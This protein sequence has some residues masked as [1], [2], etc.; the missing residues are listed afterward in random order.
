[1]ND[2]TIVIGAGIA[3][4]AAA[5]KLR[6]AG[7]DVLV[8]EASDRVGG[9]MISISH[10]GDSAEA[11]AQGIHTGYTET[12]KLIE[13]YGL[14]GDLVPQLNDQA[15][16]L[17]R[18]GQH[19]YP[20]GGVGM[21]KM[22]GWRGSFDLA[23]YLTKYMILAKKF[24]LYETHRDIPEYD[25]VSIADA[26]KW[27]GDDFRDFMLLPGAHAMVGSDLEHTNLYHFMNLMKLVLTTKVM[28]L[29]GGNASLPQKIASTLDVRL[30][31]PVKQLSFQQ[32]KVSG[33]ELE[34]GEHISAKH[35]IV[36]C[37]I[38]AAA[39][40]VPEQLV[41][42]SNFLTSFKNIPLSLVYFFL[43]R[44]YDTKAYA[45][46]GHAY[47]KT[48]FNMALN[49]TVK[50]PHSVPSGKGLISAWPCYPDSGVIDKKSDDEVISKAL[51]DLDIFFPGMEGMIAETRVQRH[52][53][54]LG[55]ISP[56]MHAKIITFKKQVEDLRGVSF[57]NSD[58]DG[59][60]MES[61]VR[62]GLRAAG[63]VIGGY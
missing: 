17:D 47:R 6:N 8:L 62:S 28:T 37:P 39:K 61:G 10:N 19:L 16:Y 44:P 45:Y 12:L 38:G 54:G 63:R 31:S 26:L 24:S 48:T 36:A 35:I 60:H 42:T 53:W 18:S 21:L 57:A 51:K 11:G 22:L 32:G 41:P 5:S 25:N 4:M 34:S 46:M 59:V 56:G 9:R 43:D 7:R 30:N 3:G 14:T 50:T 23:R 55:R 52:R 13:E 15:C 58:Y 40:L 29:R 20:Q 27:A 1:M 33:V 49:H 2:C